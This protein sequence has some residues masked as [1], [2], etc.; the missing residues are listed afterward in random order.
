MHAEL[1]FES[2]HPENNR[3]VLDGHDITKA[4]YV[5]GFKIAFGEPP[6]PGE[7]NPIELHLVVGCDQVDVTGD[8]A[9]EIA[10]GKEVLLQT[11][12]PPAFVEEL[13]TALAVAIDRSGAKHSV[14]PIDVLMRY[15]PHKYVTAGLGQDIEVTTSTAAT[16]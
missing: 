1:H 16:S 6:A 7:V 10:R 14:N 2:D 12:T 15:A 4:V 3:I 11:E 5:D 9:V 8:L 13:T